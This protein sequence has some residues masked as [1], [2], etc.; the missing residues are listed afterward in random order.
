MKESTLSEQTKLLTIIRKTAEG[1]LTRWVR[2]LDQG[3]NAHGQSLKGYSDSY[4]KQIA[5]NGNAVYY[6][7]GN[8]SEGRK[9]G[10]RRGR[11][12]PK[13]S[14]PTNLLVTG[15][16]RRSMHTRDITD[17]AELY[18]QGKHQVTG[19]SL[20]QT[21]SYLHDK[22]FTG[23]FEPDE[24]KDLKPLEEAIGEAFKQIVLSRFES[25]KLL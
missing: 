17:G 20:E 2:A 18:F 19:Q 6:Y 5:D 4:R 11:R 22:G 13:S 8:N 16:L 21:A 15:S 24:V 7:T 25:K 14:S 3:Q 9:K 10:V 23:W 12:F 1:W